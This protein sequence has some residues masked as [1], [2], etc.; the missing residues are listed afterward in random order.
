M[1][2]V[3]Y[4][5]VSD[6]DTINKN[7]TPV[8]TIT[9]V[10]KNE[11][12]VENPIIIFENSGMIAGNYCYI[13]EFGRYYYIVNQTILSNNRVRVDLTVDVLE[14]FKNSI[15]ALDVIVDNSTGSNDNY[16]PSD[17]WVSNVKTK[18]DI[19]NFPSGFNESGAFILITAGG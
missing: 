4:N 3:F 14:S 9:G 8:R 6:D 16:L 2:V 10:L 17:L 15:L 5:N 19:L 7:I 12:S 13:S 18:T 1:D 11:C